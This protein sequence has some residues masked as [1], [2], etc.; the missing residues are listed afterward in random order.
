VVSYVVVIRHQ[1]GMDYVR[2]H[3]ASLLP[4][5][6]FIATPGQQIGAPCILRLDVVTDARWS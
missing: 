6:G 1:W 4:K 3:I 5:F 2:A